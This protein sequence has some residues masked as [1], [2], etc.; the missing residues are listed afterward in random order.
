MCQLCSDHPMV[1]KHEMLRRLSPLARMLASRSWKAGKELDEQVVDTEQSLC[2]PVR[3]KG[4]ID[5]CT[6][7]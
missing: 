5:G 4:S 3:L 2:A 1:V 7:T 6:Y